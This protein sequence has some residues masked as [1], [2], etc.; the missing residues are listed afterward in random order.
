MALAAAE[1]DRLD[2]QVLSLF[3]PSVRSGLLDYFARRPDAALTVQEIRLR[4][5]RP[6]SIVRPDGDSLIQPL[7]TQ[8]DIDKTL[9]L[10]TDC[11]YYALENELANGYIT[12]PGGHRV[13]LTGQ[14]AV[15]ADGS[16]RIREVS[17]FCFRVAREVKGVA[18]RIIRHLMGPWP[19]RLASTLI[20][21]PPGCGKTTLLRDLCRLAGEGVPEI[22]L[23][24]AQVGIVDERSEIAACHRGVPQHDVGPRAD[25]LDRCPKARGMMMLQR[26]MGPGVIATD[27]IGSEEDARAVAAV[28]AGGASVL[29]TCH[30]RDI[31]QVKKQPHS[32]WL[33]EKGYFQKAVV[34][35]RRLGPGTVEYV[36]DVNGH[37]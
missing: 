14:T 30:G 2:R 34:L 1:L 8:D 19:G 3:S 36:G 26:S 27:E 9:S 5:G 25:V 18:E 32:A 13:G 16:I 37:V 12:V 7:V 29:A 24:P 33:I 4:K 15:W 17:G 28:L 22:G 21:S 11:S 35:S 20:I 10:I 31:L 23:R 6:V